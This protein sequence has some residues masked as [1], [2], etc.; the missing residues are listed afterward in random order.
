MTSLR[1]CVPLAAVL[2]VGA[3]ATPLAS[4]APA[5][6]CGVDLTAPQIISAIRT[7]A[8]YQGVAWSTAPQTFEGNYDPCATL[9]TVL[10]TVDGATGSSP[11][12]AL[13]FHDGTYLGTATAKPYG[14]T[15]LNRTRSSDDTVVLDYATPGACTACAPAAVTSVRYQWDGGRV[16][17]LDPPPA[18]S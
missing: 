18:R 12:T 5:A 15:T 8:P 4:P 14:F 9:S 16:V 3:C 7:L 17:M 2:V 1:T 13:M 11:E 10:V 6:Q